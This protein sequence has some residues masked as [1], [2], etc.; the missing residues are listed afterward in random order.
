MYGFAVQSTPLF[1]SSLITSPLSAPRRSVSPRSRHGFWDTVLCGFV[2]AMFCT[3]LFLPSGLLSRVRKVQITFKQAQSLVELEEPFPFGK[4]K[5]YRK[6]PRPQSPWSNTRLDLK[7]ADFLLARRVEIHESVCVWVLWIES[8]SDWCG[9]FLASP[10]LTMK[11][12]NE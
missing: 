4:G 12:E 9:F 6:S 2:T 8:G 5:S 10:A 1:L 11:V 3:F 7:H